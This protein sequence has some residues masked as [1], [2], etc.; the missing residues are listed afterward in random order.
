MARLGGFEPPT[1][2]FVARYSIQLS[3]S[4]AKPCWTAPDNVWRCLPLGGLLGPVALAPSG[5]SPRCVDAPPCAARTPVEPL[6]VRIPSY[7]GVCRVLRVY[8]ETELISGAAGRIRT[9]D[10]LVRS[11]VLYPAELQPRIKLHLPSGATLTCC[12]YLF[13]LYRRKWRRGRDS[14]PRY[15]CSYGSLAG[16]W[17]Q[18][19][20][21]LSVTTARILP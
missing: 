2:W 20:T 13:F 6:S 12:Q 10:R 14:N 9:S 1:A 18:P 3:Y 17:F 19:L 4:R 21:H 5:S 8:D 15:D 7:S 11:Q 16:N